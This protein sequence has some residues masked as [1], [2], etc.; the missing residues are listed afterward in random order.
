MAP[1]PCRLQEERCIVP[2]E[3]TH[4]NT[5]ARFQEPSGDAQ[6][7]GT[8]ELKKLSTAYTRYMDAQ[9]IPIVTGKG[10]RD[11]RELELKPWDRLGV[12][13]AFINLSNTTDLLGLHV[14]E[15]PPGG[16]TIPAR[17]CYEETYWVV[18]GEGTTEQSL[19]DGSGR[20]RFEWRKNSL[21]AI[22]MNAEY[23]IVN[24]RKTPAL[25]LAGNTAPPVI[26]TFDD[27]DFV[28]RN[29]HPFLGRFDGSADYGKPNLETLATPE[30]GRA[31]WRTNVVPDI[32]DVELPLDNQRSPG[33]RRI[34][35]NM[36]GGRFYTF[37]GQTESGRYSK[38]HAH[39]SGAVLIC[40]KGEGYTL[41]WPRAVGTTP[42][43]SGHGD[44]V[45]R[46]DY[47]QGGI[48]AAAPGGGLWF[49]QHFGAS[50]G[51]LR[52]LVFIGGAPG[53]QYA[54][55]DGSKWINL[56]IEDGGGSVSYRSEDPY[57]RQEFHRMLAARGASS[58]MAPE[59]Y[60]PR[61]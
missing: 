7:A 24:A 35:P 27:L 21:F 44:E 46:V 8:M 58:R 5:T 45:E 18:E 50:S 26:N 10:V 20:Q 51:P 33:Y 32:V 34:E 38:A 11:V 3:V 48:V 4:Q 14:I 25:L 59:L 55:L 49:H 37:I 17:Q 43:E 30:L 19:P 23:Q 12:N 13:A 36:A 47:V 39:A 15:I 42:W 22:P 61:P 41:N 6:G 56:D 31:M 52:Q 2:E 60:A 29:V 16:A 28:F 1:R 40:V 54:H 53:H 9:G 57:I